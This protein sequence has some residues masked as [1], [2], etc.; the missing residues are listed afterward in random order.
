MAK[1]RV[2]RRNETG[3]MEEIEVEPQIMTN[4]LAELIGSQSDP[5]IL[6]VERGAI[7]KY[8]QAVGDPNPL[9]SDVEYAKKSKYGELICPLG[10]FGWPVKPRESAQPSLA[11]QN[12]HNNYA[13]EMG[14]SN[15]NVRAVVL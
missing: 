7:R 15:W 1:V 11:S 10:F 3:Q 14:R 9:Y 4:E 8:A 13:S 5:V 12:C 2:M 6:E